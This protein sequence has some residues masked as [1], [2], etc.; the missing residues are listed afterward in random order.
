M[1]DLASS[2]AKIN[3]IEVSADAALTESLFIKMGASINYLIDRALTN[4]TATIL[5]PSV[6]VRTT[7]YT[8]PAGKRLIGCVYIDD[9]TGGSFSSPGDLVSIVSNSVERDLLIQT[10]GDGS[11]TKTGKVMIG[12]VLDAAVVVK[13]MR[14]STSNGN[15]RFGVTGVLISSTV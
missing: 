1:A 4:V 15:V 5:G 13:G 11:S 9:H 12:V 10:I 7:I 8:V 3:D 14:V 6:N 2:G